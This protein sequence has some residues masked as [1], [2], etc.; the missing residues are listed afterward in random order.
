MTVEELEIVIRAKVGDALKGLAQIKQ[1]VQDTVKQTMEPMKQVVSQTRVMAQSGTSNIKKTTDSMKTLGNQTKQTTVQQQILIDKLNDMKADLSTLSAKEFNNSIGKNLRAE[2]EKTENK[3]ISLQG[4]T[5]AVGKSTNDSFNKGLKSVK[6]FVLGLVSV[7]SIYALISRGIQSYLA[8]ND[9]AQRK[10]ELTSNTI[11]AILAPAMEKLLDIIQYIVIGV[12]LLI[13]MFTGFNALAKVTT[14]NISNAA[15]ETK[16][17]NKELTA[18]D[19][20]TN[21]SDPDTGGVDLTSDYS[22]LADFQSK[23]AEVQALFDK[24]DIQKVVDNIK[25]L[26]KWLWD[27]RDAIVALGIALGITFGVLKISG[28]ISNISKLIGGGTGAAATGLAGLST[29]LLALA[30]VFVITLVVKGYNE[31]LKD[32]KT[33]NKEL[34]NNTTMTKS[35]NDNVQEVADTF[36]EYYNQ[37]K[38]SNEQIQSNIEYTDKQTDSI[39]NQIQKLEEQKT[40]LG[41]VTG[42]NEKLTEQQRLLVE[43]LESTNNHYEDL[44]EQG[45][46]TDSQA[47]DYKKSLEEQMKVL[48]YLGYDVDNLKSKYENI[49]GNYTATITAQLN[50]QLTAQFGAVAETLK[51]QITSLTIGFNPSGG[52]YSSM[53]K[54]SKF[55][56]GGV[57][58]KP[59]YSLTGEYQNAKSDPEIISPQSIMKDTML[60]AFSQI[61]PSMQGNDNGSKEAVLNINGKELARALFPDLKNEGLRVGTSTLIRRS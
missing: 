28:L 50:D 40:I 59:T 30:T 19:E 24:W 52:F 61:L 9:V 49:E 18:M 46:L 27:N 4:K 2:I 53:Y 1:A 3:L 5:V 12:A 13:Q 10:Y 26:S 34:D 38:L 16:A 35:V 23:I 56:T 20:I 45:L 29:I 42:S 58:N 31:V 17:L 37:G 11:G 22:A 44:Y 21:L 6:R 54:P 32:I 7:G 33:L 47:K 55:A 14:K 36:W 51:K 25:D 43:R 15:S 39:V 8:T 41:I 60:D 48:D 57:V